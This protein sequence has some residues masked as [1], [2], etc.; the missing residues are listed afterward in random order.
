[1]CGTNLS[2][3]CSREPDSEQLNS[4]DW[5]SL[6][7]ARERGEHAPEFVPARYSQ[8]TYTPSG[9]SAQWLCDRFNELL[10]KFRDSQGWKYKNARVG[11]I[12]R[13]EGEE[14]RNVEGSGILGVPTHTVMT[15]G[16]A[17]E[18]V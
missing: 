16:S 13:F 4:F 1:M 15:K 6:F 2:R 5:Q 7:S 3:K 17:F 12:R 18:P 8:L 9:I 14:E 10:T 11:T